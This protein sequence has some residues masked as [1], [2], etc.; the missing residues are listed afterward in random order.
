[1]S[2]ICLHH[3]TETT[4]GVLAVFTQGVLGAVFVRHEANHSPLYSANFKG[5]LDFTSTVSVQ[6][7]TVVF[8]YHHNF[9]FGLFFVVLSD[10]C[11]HRIYSFFGIFQIRWVFTILLVP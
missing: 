2:E 5:A 9:L 11:V 4:S 7:T 1:M 10:I 3:H 6:F 8:T